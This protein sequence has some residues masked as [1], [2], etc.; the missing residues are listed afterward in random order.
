MWCQLDST[1]RCS[2]TA[3]GKTQLMFSTVVLCRGQEA[4]VGHLP[5]EQEA[6][7]GAARLSLNSKVQGSSQTLPA[8]A[9]GSV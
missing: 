7:E 9:A 6:R 4:E 8:A 5:P 1:Q 2:W 3:A